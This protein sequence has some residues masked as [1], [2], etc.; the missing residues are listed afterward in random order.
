MPV[1]EATEGLTLQPNR[2]YVIPPNAQ[3]TISENQLRLAP[4]GARVVGRRFMPV[5]IFFESLA[6]NYSNRAI[7]IVLSGFDGDGA[8]GLKAIKRA[9]GITF[10]QT[11]DTAQHSDMPNTAVETGYVD[12]ILPPSEMAH[13]LVSLAQ[14]P[15]VGQPPEPSQTDEVSRQSDLASVY[16]LLRAATGIDFSQ[17]KRT[18]FERRL[19]RRMALYRVTS[20]ADYLEQ[21]QNNPAEIKALYRDVLLT[22]T[23]F[24]RDPDAFAFLKIAVFP[25]LLEQKTDAPIR[26]WTAGCATGEECYSLAIC[27]CEFL[28]ERNANLGIQIFGTDVS[29]EAIE[30]AR[31]GIYSESQMAGVSP[32]RRSRFFTR[33]E[34]RYQISKAIRELCVFARQNLGSDPPFSSI[35][36]VSCRNV[37]IYFAPALQKRVLAIF[38]YS[39]NASG[40]LWLGSSES[41]GETSDLFTVVDRKHKVYS[42]SSVVNR[43]NF[44]F[45]TSDYR[46]LNPAALPE[47][48]IP[49]VSNHSNVQRQADQI[50]LNRYA[51]VGVVVNE[52]L[53]I[54][55]FR[56]DTSLYLKP[57]PGEPSFNLLKM[58]QPSL[59]VELRSA[60]DQARAQGMVSRKE[61][62][63]IKN[64]PHYIHLEVTPIK[65]PLSQ[66]RSY[67]VLFEIGPLIVA[68][69]AQASEAEDGDES[70]ATNPDMSQLERELA[71]TKQE[72]LDTQ[73][74]LQATIEEHEATNQRLTTA[75]EEILSSN[76]ELQSTNEELQTAKEEIQ[77]TNEELKTT[78][79]EL[80]SRNAD[81][82]LVN[83]DLLNL[84]NNVNIPI[85]MLSSDLCI[86]RFT[87]TAQRL[88]NLI[89]ADVGRPISNIRLNIEIPD[90]ETLI[91][92]VMDTLNSQ[93]HEVR[94][95]QGHWYR[96]CIRPYRTAEH[97]I[98]G[99]VIAV[100]DIDDMKNTLQQ[101]EISRLYAES[102]VETVR[103][104]LV[105][106][107]ADLRVKT[108]NQAFYEIFQVFPSE[109]ENRLIFE[110]GNGQWNIPELRSR[111]ETLLSG[112]MPLQNLEIEYSFERVGYKVMLL[113]AREIVQA[114]D[115][116]M[117]L[118]SIEDITERKQA[119]M[120]RIQL[121]Q[122]QAARVEAEAANAGKDQF[123][124][125]LSHELRTPLN[126]ILGWTSILLRQSEPAPALLNRALTTI[127]RSARAQ[128]Q[129][130]NDLLDVSRVIQGQLSLRPQAVN[131]TNLLNAAI[132]AIQPSAEQKNIQFN[133][134]LASSPRVLNLDPSR[135]Q[136]VFSNVLSNAVKFTPE[137]G[138]I[139]VSLVYEDNQARVE[140]TDTGEGISAEFLPYVFDR[141]RQT[142]SSNT[143]QYGGLGLGLAIVKQM[144]EAHNGTVQS[145][146]PD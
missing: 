116:Q 15:Y 95:G 123:L 3:M 117:I 67:L 136:Q 69:T 126:A 90:F 21:L 5:D 23:R 51:P 127:E 50:V 4:R 87:P 145:A 26:I 12:F 74:Y 101:L 54:L 37:L 47:R 118:L 125:V 49:E 19:R 62:L 124:S 45:V 22:V 31:Q 66:E 146:A 48:T 76:E 110:L 135:I 141:F 7:G 8:Q 46:A 6:D 133:S 14:H 17:Y 53:N 72:L 113:N 144:V 64:N 96:L 138:E 121:I 114:T 142:Q 36:L 131:L 11:E 77:A 119:D 60:I 61:G 99:A 27:L 70:S 102:I 88:F 129:L 28:S 104:P 18:T 128:N 33:T 44:D 59:L 106:L 105:V 35:D 82:R 112:D 34:G 25:T 81:A 84:L 92:Q 20:L 39:L 85:V 97:Q 9:G 143:R 40:F 107:A 80:Q 2:V 16:I 52:R 41:V 83:D 56:G 43:L 38:H 89:P 91:L 115:G 103:E 1:N 109:T 29:E 100:V 58:V 55:H 63:Q 79:E 130:I 108:A 139:R 68:G 73:A 140:V 122:E 10:A 71:T 32:E 75:N 98:D 86:R 30:T 42:C 134:D 78:N 120:E 111:L 57:A 94:D 93:E 13:K 24:F 132:E 137:E 65:N